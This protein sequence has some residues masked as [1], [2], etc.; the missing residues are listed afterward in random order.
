MRI[1]KG[2]QISP[3][4]LFEQLDYPKEQTPAHQTYELFMQIPPEKQQAMP[5][6]LKT[7][8]ELL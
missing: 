1:C 3:K 4:S 8:K 2:L 7:A 6:L 5:D